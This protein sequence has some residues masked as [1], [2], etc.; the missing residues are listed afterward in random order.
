MRQDLAS[1][2]AALDELKSGMAMLGAQLGGQSDF[3]YGSIDQYGMGTGGPGRGF[4]ERDTSLA[5]ATNNTATRVN[6]RTAD[7]P[8]IAT[9]Y[10]QEEQVKGEST[11]KLQETLQAARDR[12][13]EAISDNTIPARYHGPLKDYFDQLNATRKPDAPKADH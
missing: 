12:A 5:E 3:Q 4:G 8:P 1:A 9:W 6:N 2:K 11:A 7:G 10:T 13:S